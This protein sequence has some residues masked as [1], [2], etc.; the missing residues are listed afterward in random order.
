VSATARFLRYGL[1]PLLYAGVIFALSHR[2]TPGQVLEHGLDKLAH[3]AAY[4]GLGVLTLRALWGHGGALPRALR[5]TVIAC[6]L[7][8]VSDELHQHF[9]PGRHADVQDWVADTLGASAGAALTARHVRRRGRL[10]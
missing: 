9:V 3:F 4:L 8:A 6:S 2:E 10:P 5:W 7:Y 1:P